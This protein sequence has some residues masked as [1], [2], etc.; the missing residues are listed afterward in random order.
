MNEEME[1]FEQYLS[2]QPMRRIPSEWREEIL[3][4][5][6]RESWVESRRPKGLWSSLVAPRLYSA[7]WPH[8]VA[9]AGL[10]AVWLFLL[11]VDFSARERAPAVAE[12]GS[13]LLAELLGPRDV[14]D[15]D[16]SKPSAPLPRSE[17]EAMAT[18]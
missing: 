16:R 10:A 3:A 18:V 1:Q 11:G 9:W 13:A 5:A 15:A 7:F 8:P 6:G 14:R 12:S 17:A 2:R 4:A